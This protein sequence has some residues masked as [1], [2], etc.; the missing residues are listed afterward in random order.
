M[1]W[2]LQSRDI[3]K[4]VV[5]TARE[6]GVGIVAYSPLGRGFLSN[7]FTKR[8]DLD[9]KD[10]RLTNPRFSEENFEKNA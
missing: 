5:P 7:T 8:A 2:S 1:E 6:L 3:E 10:W 4:T 9:D